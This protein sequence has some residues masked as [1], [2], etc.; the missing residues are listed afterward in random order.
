MQILLVILFLIAVIVGA[1][2]HEFQT[3]TYWFFILF[4][5]V[6]LKLAGA[7]GFLGL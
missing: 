3:S 1:V 2:R 6:A 7:L 5:V 4:G